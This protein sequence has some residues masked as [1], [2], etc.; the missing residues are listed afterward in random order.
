MEEN[1]PGVCLARRREGHFRARRKPGMIGSERQ[2]LVQRVQK[3]TG[4]CT[5]GQRRWKPEVHSQRCHRFAGQTPG[6]HTQ[7]GDATGGAPQETE[8]AG[9]S[10]AG[11]LPQGGTS[12]APAPLLGIYWK[13]QSE[14]TERGSMRE[15]RDAG[16]RMAAR[17]EW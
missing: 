3:E 14:K 17:R 5:V 16:S 11:C 2:R 8:A 15:T 6:R 12:P 13:M 4:D 7:P 9:L 10:G 1:A